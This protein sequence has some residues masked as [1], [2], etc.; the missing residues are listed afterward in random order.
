M[1][2]RL[3]TNEICLNH[4]CPTT[5]LMNKSV[6]KTQQCKRHLHDGAPPQKLPDPHAQCGPVDH[7]LN[8]ATF[9]RMHMLSRMHSPQLSVAKLIEVDRLLK[10]ATNTIGPCRTRLELPLCFFEVSET[11][12]LNCKYQKRSW[13][14]QIR[15]KFLV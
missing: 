9:R 15:C 2:V 13:S 1:K 4:A 14:I 10:S 11:F 8:L 3:E 6:Q 12:N 5:D 7:G